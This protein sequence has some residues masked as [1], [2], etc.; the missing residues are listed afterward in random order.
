MRTLRSHL[1]FFELEIPKLVILYGHFDSRNTGWMTATARALPALEANVDPDPHSGPEPRKHE[2][3]IDQGERV[4]GFRG[5]L[6]VIASRSKKK[7]GDLSVHR[8]LAAT[9]ALK[10]SA[11]DGGKVCN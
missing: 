5:E 3:E 8:W 4:Y 2:G 6:G 10:T 11:D 9:Q 1:D 7:H